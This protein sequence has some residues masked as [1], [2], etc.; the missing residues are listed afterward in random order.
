MDAFLIRVAARACAAGML[1]EQ[2]DAMAWAAGER[3]GP[4]QAGRGMTPRRGSVLASASHSFR[5]KNIS[6]IG[7]FLL[8][9]LLSHTT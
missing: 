8:T 2:Q 7:N 9:D 3:A 4:D 1:A 5:V 6:Y